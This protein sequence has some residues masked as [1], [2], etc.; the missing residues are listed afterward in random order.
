MLM[1][2]KE[3]EHHRVTY[4]NR[5][6]YERRD[7]PSS[8]RDDLSISILEEAVLRCVVGYKDDS[9]PISYLRVLELNSFL[10]T[11]PAG[12]LVRG[13]SFVLHEGPSA[14]QWELFLLPKKD[15]D[16]NDLG[17]YFFKIWSAKNVFEA[18]YRSDWLAWM[19][20]TMTD[21]QR[22]IPVLTCPDD[23][24]LQQLKKFEPTDMEQLLYGLF[25]FKNIHG[26]GE[27]EFYMNEHKC[28]VSIGDG[29]VDAGTT[30]LGHSLR[31]VVRYHLKQI[32]Q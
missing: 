5:P 21:K 7:V 15:V 6:W 31:N 29:Y 11:Q 12:C 8:A 26:D 17:M 4:N 30:Q 24:Y 22:K 20:M 13:V 16:Q 28:T 3:M 25:I 10:D 19:V 14:V 27:Y 18:T 23:F 2:G 32:K 9:N 1:P